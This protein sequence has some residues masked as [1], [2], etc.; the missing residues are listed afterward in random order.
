MNSRARKPGQF[1]PSPQSGHEQEHESEHEREPE[2]KAPVGA[3]RPVETTVHGTV[4]RDDYAWMRDRDDPDVLAYLEAENEYTQARSPRIRDIAET[5]YEE[6]KSRLRETDLSV[7]VRKDGWLY[8]VRTVEGQSYSIHC[9]RRGSMESGAEEILLDLNELADGH[10]YLGLGAFCISPDHRL[11]AYAT[12]TEGNEVYTLRIL[13]LATRELIGKPIES[14]SGS[15]A[16]ANDNQTL[17]YDT[18]DDALRPYRIYR[19]RLGEETADELVYEEV[20]ERFYIGVTR[21]RSDAYLLIEAESMSTTET[22]VLS[23]DDPQGTFRV[24]A[25]RREGIEYEVEHQGERFLIVTNDGAENFRLMEAPVEDPSPASWRERIP[26]RPD[27]YLT[28]VDAFRDHLVLHE[29]RNG[30]TTLRVEQLGTGDTHEIR[31]EETACTVEPSGNPEYDTT[32]LRLRYT[33][34]VTPATLY[35]YDMETRGRTFLKRKEVVGGYDRESYESWRMF[36]TSKDGARVPVSIVRRRDFATG[37][38]GPLLL[39]AYGAYGISSDPGFSSGTLSLLDRGITLA[40]A[41]VRGG[42]EMGRTWYEDGRL[43]NKQNTFDD[44]IACAEALIRAELTSTDRLAI[45]GGSAGGLLVGA[46]L[47][48]R[49]DLFR[50]AVAQVPFVDVLNT[51]LDPTLPLTVTEYDQWGDPNDP[52]VFERIRAY[53]PYENVRAQPYPD[54]LVTAG[55]NDPRVPYWE[56]AKW[57]AKLRATATGDPLLLLQTNLSAGHGGASGR[58]EMLRETA[59]EYAFVIDRL[60][61]PAASRPQLS[62][63]ASAQSRLYPRVEPDRTGRLRV[64]DR[65]ELRWELSGNPEGRPAIFLHGGPGSGAGPGARRFFDPERFRILV[66]DQRGSGGS[67][68]NAEWRD[69]TTEDLVADIDRLREHLSLDAP[70]LIFGGSWGS[71]LALAYAQATRNAIA[72]L[73]LRGVFLARLE[74]VDHLYHGGTSIAFPDAYARLERLV[75]RTDRTGYPQTLF[76]L[77]T[78]ENPEIRQRAI[79]EWARYELRLSELRMTDD[80]CDERL[81]ALEF[82]ALSVLENH[83]MRHGCFLDE[84]QLLHEAPRIAHLPIAIVHGRYDALC[85]PSGAHALAD[86]LAN[87]RLVFTRAGHS[88]NEPETLEALVD[89]VEWVAS[90]EP[91]VDSSRIA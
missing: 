40:I 81:E 90:F 39:C 54:L 19:H 70:A 45:L 9:R 57:I 41:H 87:C 11:L 24:V 50:A 66:F 71:T 20:D 13:D 25:P 44:T 86:R 78:H 77:V 36:A 12:D 7:P 26:G 31:F 75:G 21:T 48:Q 91:E 59:F 49:P 88:A 33:S 23:A 35:D 73:V 6:M 74:D 69:N 61:A 89:A 62:A 32:T 3:R 72:G 2:H 55:L 5:V 17:F 18:V 28:G 38:P 80:R 29:R 68:P 27:V 67:T 1:V 46:V 52:E 47:N 63:T 15:V 8:Y 53:A 79:R 83:Y 65:H 4:L 60:G 56:A 51:M 43:A 30:Y 64:S 42:S 82:T 84:G 14:V 76:D 16:W 34:L 10:D 37:Q 85:P 58:Y 22:L